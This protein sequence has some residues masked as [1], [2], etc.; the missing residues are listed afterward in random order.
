[1]KKVAAVDRQQC[2][3]HFLAAKIKQ[4]TIVERMEA[5]FYMWSL[6]RLYAEDHQQ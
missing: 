6:P 5:V 1:M 3:Q 2:S 4:A